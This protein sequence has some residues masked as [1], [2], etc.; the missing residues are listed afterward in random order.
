MSLIAQPR[1][2]EDTNGASPEPCQIE[3]FTFLDFESPALVLTEIL[4]FSLSLYQIFYGIYGQCLPFY[5]V[6]T[7]SLGDFLYRKILTYQR[8]EKFR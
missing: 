6:Y 3:P 5:L 4:A 8:P 1:F 2:S 7:C